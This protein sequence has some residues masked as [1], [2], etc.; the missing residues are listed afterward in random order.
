M[1]N[2]GIVIAYGFVCFLKTPFVVLG[3]IW[4]SYL[5][6]GLHWSEILERGEE[7]R[8]WAICSH[9]HPGRPQR[10]SPCVAIRFCA[11]VTSPSMRLTWALGSM[12]TS[13]H[14]GELDEN[15]QHARFIRPLT[16]LLFSMRCCFPTSC[17]RNWALWNGHLRSFSRLPIPSLSPWFQSLVFLFRF[18]ASS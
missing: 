15:K 6:G 1:L 8:P 5:L 7:K 10:D 17:T 4:G 14:E 3:R 2:G 12:W 16:H 11:K 9:Q 13:Y 18:L